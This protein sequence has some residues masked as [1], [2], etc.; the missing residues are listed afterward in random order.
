MTDE[1]KNARGDLKAVGAPALPFA[2]PTA[3]E[4]WPSEMM[5]FDFDFGAI[6]FAIP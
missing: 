5:L 6:F 2:A 3:D 4:K 1:T